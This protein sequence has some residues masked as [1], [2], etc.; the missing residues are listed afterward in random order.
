MH[1][2]S[3]AKETLNIAIH[4]LYS[5]LELIS[6]VYCSNGTICHVP[7]S[8]QVDAGNVM[9]ASFGI[10]SEQK[11]FKCVLLYKL[12]RKYANKTENQP[13]NNTA[14]IEDTTTGIYLLVVGVIKDYD[15]V[16]YAC[17]IECT[18]E[19]PWDEDKL[20][21]LYQEYNDRFRNNCKSNIIIWS[22]YSSIVMKTELR[23]SYGS[24]Y[25]LDIIISEETEEYD[26]KEPMKIDPRRSVLSL[27][28]LIMLIYTVRLTVRPS[29]K[30]NIHNHC[31]NVDLVS[32]TYITSD[33]LECHRPP[34]YKVSA[35]DTMRVSFIIKLGYGSYDALIYRIQRKKPH[36]STENREDTSS[37]VHLLVV[38]KISESE[39]LYAEVLLVEH[40]KRLD[41][42]TDDLEELIF[43]NNNW[44]RLYSDSTTEIWSLDDNT[45]LMTIFNIMNEDHV[46][47]ITISEIEKDNSARTPAHIINSKR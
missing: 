25:N 32:P 17:L 27:S 44:F 30:L 24:E 41:Q 15:H 19:F 36:E 6:P 10:D 40:E 3:F 23:V 8:Q 42:D 4:N 47:N 14:S 20:W 11:D 12:Q 39:E 46:L 13:N 34:D 28:M 7:P 38:W 31:L 33:K 18:D 21:A 16:F 29:F 22:T 1:I 2:V 45:A 26:M 37:A 43:E 35:G 5:D 9:E